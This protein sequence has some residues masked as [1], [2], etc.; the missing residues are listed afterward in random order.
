MSETAVNTV[1]EPKPTLINRN[2]I[3]MMLVNVCLSV[4]FYFFQPV[5]PGYITSRGISITVAGII[6]GL[7]SFTALV[8]RPWWAE[9]SPS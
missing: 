2:F 4:G 3:L 6:A 1:Q 9:R 5:L 7:F 8:V